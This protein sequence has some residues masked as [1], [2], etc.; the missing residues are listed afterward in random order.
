MKI[1]FTSTGKTWDSIMDSRF[2]RTEFIVVYNE[3][4]KELEVVD[5]SAVKNEA[6]GAGT[7]TAQKMY[8]IKPNV[9]ITGN[10]PGE[11][12]ATALKNLNMKIYVDAHNLTLE[13]AYESY[14][15]GA[16]TEI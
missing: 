12:A 13:Q 1:A 7:A 16:L 8:E 3:E 2:G 9:L 6:H 4:T 10:G 14:R 11:T 5:N 15:N